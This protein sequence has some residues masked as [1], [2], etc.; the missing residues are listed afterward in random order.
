LIY[1]DKNNK[2]NSI[3]IFKKVFQ[4]RIPNHLVYWNL[5]IKSYHILIQIFW[6]LFNSSWLKILQFT[7]SRFGISVQNSRIKLMHKI[8]S[9][10]LEI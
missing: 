8:I 7:E 6:N 9:N 4:S 3:E 5:W 2:I 10:V 1:F